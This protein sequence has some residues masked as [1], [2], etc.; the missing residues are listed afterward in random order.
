VSAFMCGGQLPALDLPDAG[1]GICCIGAVMGGPQ[2]CTCWE[3]VYDLDQQPA[4]PGPMGTR[5][6]R[7]G[8]CAYL[9]DS[10]ERRGEAGYQGDEESLEQMV[11]DGSPFSC[12]QGMRKPVKYVHPSGTEVPG[13]P[14]S[15]DPPIEDGIPYKADGTPGDLC[16]GWAARRLAYLQREAKAS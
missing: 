12:H 13:H 4:V 16:A 2:R 15:Y 11:R 1:D 7:C 10:P 8:D 9:K 5:T 3:P 6:V 14:A